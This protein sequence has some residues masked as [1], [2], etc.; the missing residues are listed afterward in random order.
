MS[1]E[2]GY[3]SLGIRKCPACDKEFEAST[4]KPM[5]KYRSVRCSKLGMNN[6]SYK[7]DDNISKSRLHRRIENRLGR[8]DRCSKCNTIGPVDLANISN[9]Y[10]HDTSDW[11]WLC[12]N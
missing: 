2:Y 6:P 12:R 8:P 1:I 11:E 5:Q 9:E 7:K 3:R 4:R 10:K